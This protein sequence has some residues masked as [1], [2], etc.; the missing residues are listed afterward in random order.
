MQ[1]F[2]YIKKIQI[3]TTKSGRPNYY[4]DQSPEQREAVVR[5]IAICIGFFS[6][7]SEGFESSEKDW[8]LYNQELGKE[9]NWA[10]GKYK[11]NP[12]VRCLWAQLI[13]QIPKMY[14]G[15]K[16]RFSQFQIDN[17]NRSLQ[18]AAKLYNSYITG[19][20]KI[21]ADHYK[22]E[23]VQLKTDYDD[24]TQFNKL[25]QKELQN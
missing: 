3:G 13:M 4:Y 24:K 7:R 5:H 14:A 20:H 19:T 25:F 6:E 2:Y 8:K 12:S 15:K 1:Q 23:M 16:A 18:V 22:I 21:T 17:F 10:T 9:V 11:H